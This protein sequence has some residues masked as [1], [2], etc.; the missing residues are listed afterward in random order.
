MARRFA[1]LLVTVLAVLAARPVHPA[2]AQ[3]APGLR[4]PFAA[5]T[6]WKIMQGYNGGTHSS[7]P[8][9]YALDLVREDGPT[10]GADVLA[11]AAGTVWWMN[12]P[13][14]GNGCLLIKLDGSSGLI[15]ELCH[16][17][18]RPF[19]TD[20]PIEAGQ[21]VG[22]VGPAG[23]V[24]NNGMA[25]LHI[26]MH[27][28]PDFGVTRIPAPFAAPDGLPLEGIALAP[29]GSANQFVCPGAT[30]R[31]AITSTNGA[32]GT[33]SSPV[34]SVSAVVGSAAPSAA[35]V[36]A[37]PPAV[38][39]APGSVAQI[40]GGGC[41]NVREGP[42]ITARILTCLPDGFLVT[43]AEGPISGDGRTWWRLEGLGWAAG[44]FLLGVS[45][46]APAWRVGAGVVV[47]A[48][49]R[50]CLNLR[51]APGVAAAV[52]LCLPS[53]ARLTITDGP[54]EADGRT[55]WQLDGR[56]WAAAEYLRLRDGG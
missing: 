37:A 26:S 34:N 9:R 30:C 46:A 18:A 20:E 42:G 21:P 51:E 19:R 3:P 40:T 24:G 1:P 41:L 54:R 29:D 43:V 45:P 22:S 4:L 27:R 23:S 10:A 33:A 49:E 28:T 14:A 7:G 5:G 17:I 25:H 56:G 16:I 32:R 55:W 6:S 39:L 44:D 12:P 8:E 13:G 48:G 52:I 15:V 38:V 36:L 50:D 2:S 35:S 31:P 53:G 47:D 11:P